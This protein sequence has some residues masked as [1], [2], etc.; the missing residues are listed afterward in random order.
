VEFARIV[1]DQKNLDALMLLTLADG[2]GTSADAWS[3]WKE[4]LVWQLYHA[5]SQYLSD[6]EAFYEQ[7]KIERE[8]LQKQVTENLG[9]DY[10]EEV[11]AHFEFMPDNYFRAFEVDDVASHLQLF[12]KFFTNLY[13]DSKPSVVPVIKWEAFSGQGHSIVSFCSWDRR[14]LLAKIAGSFSTIPINILSADIY[15]RGDHLVLDVFRVCDAR[16]KAVT[17]PQEM[18]EVEET[19]RQSLENEHFDF[20]L[21]IAKAREKNRDPNL[22]EIDIATKITI[23]N[24]AHPAYTLVQVQTP[25]RLGLL[26]DVLSCLG[27][28]GVYIALSRIST[29]KGAA[30]DT[31]Y[32]ADAATRNKIIDAQRIATLQEELQQAALAAS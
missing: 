11:D 12:R 23:D 14:E 29:E 10:A 32:V 18:A 25:D 28:A 9:A 13:R 2:Q 24:K 19:L 1:K 3:D 26:Y 17:D 27:R 22:Q 31:F 21:L 7:T 6:Q 20:Q 30:I 15:S 5:T 8:L 4:S 16:S